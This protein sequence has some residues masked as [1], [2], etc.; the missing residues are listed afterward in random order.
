MHTGISIHNNTRG[1]GAR[2]REYIGSGI[3]FVLFLSKQ[4]YFTNNS[5]SS[6]VHITSEVTSAAMLSPG[7]PQSTQHPPGECSVSTLAA[8]VRQAGPASR[9]AAAE[10]PA[11][12]PQGRAVSRRHAPAAALPNRT[13]CHARSPR[14]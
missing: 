11:A 12:V 10:A 8:A 1:R 13:P 6:I 5:V 3:C 4:R 2:D 9:P 14:N 7:S